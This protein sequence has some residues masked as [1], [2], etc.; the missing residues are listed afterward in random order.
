MRHPFRMRQALA[1]TAA[2]LVALCAACGSGA[3]PPQRVLSRYEIATG[4]LIVR[5]CGFSVPL[6]GAAGRSLWLFCDTVVTTRR[7]QDVGV[8]ILGAG[9]AAEGPGTAGRGPRAL[10]EVS[11]PVAD[12]PG[13]SGMPG[14][15]GGLLPPRAGPRPFLPV[16]ANL[17]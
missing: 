14:T 16:P 10:T 1:V 5:D 9:S 7:G 3:P 17:T 11:T 4:R 12:G 8:P 15:A 6:A 13:P 2:A